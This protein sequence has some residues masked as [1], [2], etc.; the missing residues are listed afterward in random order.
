M[1]SCHL[2]AKTNRTVST[3]ETEHLS[4]STTPELSGS[5]V[6]H[7]R[8]LTSSTTP[9]LTGPNSYPVPE[10]SKTVRGTSTIT[11]NLK[12]TT[13]RTTFDSVKGI[14]YSKKRTAH[15]TPVPTNTTKSRVRLPFP[16]HPLAGLS[17]GNHLRP[18]RLLTS[19]N[20]IPLHQEVNRARYR[21]VRSLPQVQFQS[22]TE[23]LP[24]NAVERRPQTPLL[25]TKENKS[26]QLQAG[27]KRKAEEQLGLPKR[28]RV[29]VLPILHFRPRAS[30]QQH[31]LPQ[32][33]QFLPPP[34]ALIDH[35]Q[36][37]RSIS[38][39]KHGPSSKV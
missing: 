23:L 13:D 15:S 10:Q 2:S 36:Q 35:Q 5:T 3:Q 6:P 12:E 11:R 19:D 21:Q 18:Q 9:T 37:W 22:V 25:P 20:P 38:R 17:L 34:Q 24:P 4:A 29:Q 33:P 32:R 14:E 26:Q 28:Q 31:P 1:S 39:S 7:T 8:V 16:Y 27:T 30:V